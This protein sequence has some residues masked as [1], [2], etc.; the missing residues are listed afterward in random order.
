MA[1]QEAIGELV[2][3]RSLST[4]LAAAAMHELMDG[5]ATQAQIGGFLVALR[6]KGETE[7]ELAGLATAMRDKALRV[8][9]E[10]EVIDT[11]GTGGDGAGTF[12]VSTTVA[13]VAAAA[14]IPVAKHGNRAMS[15][16]SGSADVLEALGVHLSLG[17]EDVAECLDQAGLAFMFAPLY[18]PAMKHAAG[19]RRELGARTVFNLLGP[20]TNPAHAKRQ[21]LGVADPVAAERIAGALQRMDCARA[22]VVHGLDGVDEISISAPTTVYDLDGGYLSVYQVTPEDLGVER[23]AR[24]EILGGTADENAEHVR[25]ILAGATGPKRAMVALNAAAALVVGGKAPDLKAGVALASEI[26][27]SRA[28]LERVDRLAQVS[29]QLAARRAG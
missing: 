6:M 3:G 8:W 23:A 29:Q 18:H 11:C 5:E 7:D 20:L 21:V 27:D 1:I 22:I 12:N 28:A 16:K 15:S 26:L 9:T 17:P 2:A 24:S 19:P 4:E 25:R 14:G 10:A 13:F